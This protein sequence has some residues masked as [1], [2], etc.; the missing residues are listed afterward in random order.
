VVRVRADQ[1]AL[2][3]RQV[4]G[5]DPGRVRA[6]QDDVG[7]DRWLRQV[8]ADLQ[9]RLVTEPVVCDAPHRRPFT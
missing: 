3:D 7:A 4:D 2:A 6:D 8:V 9:D 5:V 1:V